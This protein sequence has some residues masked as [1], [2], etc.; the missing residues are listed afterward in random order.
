MTTIA[1]FL[2][3]FLRLDSPLPVS[4][5]LTDRAP[6]ETPLVFCVL[7]FSA[8]SSSHLTKNGAGRTASFHSFSFLFCFFFRDNVL[9]RPHE[10][11]LAS[12]PGLYF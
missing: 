4:L 12:V 2:P 5:K 9:L 1:R 11:T 10:R 6:L 7:L 8:C 3:V